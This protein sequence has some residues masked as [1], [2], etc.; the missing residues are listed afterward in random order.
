[1]TRVFIHRLHGRHALLEADL[2]QELR[3]P[4]PDPAALAGI[5][6]RKLQ[7][8]DRMRALELKMASEGLN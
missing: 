8:K 5:K 6:K 1:M 2:A 3:R 4:V 7:L